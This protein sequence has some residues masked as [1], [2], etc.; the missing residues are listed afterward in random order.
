M[1]D[2]RF[3]FILGTGR[4]GSSL[5]QEVV[6]RHP[7]VGFL[8]NVE[9]RYAVARRVGRLNGAVYS[10]VPAALTQKGRARFAPSEGYRV[11]EREVSRLLTVP[12][13]PMTAEDATPWLVRRTKSFFEGRARS[14]GRPV[15][16]H[17]FT[18]WSR[19]GFLAA[20]LGDVRFVHV[21]RDGRAVANSLVQ[22]PWWKGPEDGA[23]LSQLDAS[24]VEGW[25]QSGRPHPLL[26]GLEWKAVLR[27]HE[28]ARSLLPGE[29]W[30]DV[31]YEDLLSSPREQLEAVLE[32]IGLDP[33]AAFE[34]QL[35]R[36][37]FGVRRRD[38]FESELTMRDRA[39]LDTV[40]ADD[41]SRWGY[42]ISDRRDVLGRTASG[43]SAQHPSHYAEG[44]A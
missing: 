6:S 9:D 25:V 1:T 32:H 34:R 29:A 11:L 27:S 21:V 22:M 23:L 2:A 14:Q 8:S 17:K 38:A 36:H 43:T 12:S 7:D 28:E 10:K 26:A 19:A 40:L 20:A 37:E 3:V 44:T 42:P 4:C 13:R 5:L 31:R 41:L 16:V 15:Y 39:L 30:L 35:Q 33:S 24:D 18:G